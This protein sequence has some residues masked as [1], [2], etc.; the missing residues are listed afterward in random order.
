[1][2][3]AVAIEHSKDADTAVEVVLVEVIPFLSKGT[4]AS[5]SSSDSEFFPSTLHLVEMLVQF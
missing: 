1:M 2:L 5:G 3:R 4:T